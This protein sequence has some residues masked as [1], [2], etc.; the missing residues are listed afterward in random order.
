MELRRVKKGVMTVGIPLCS[1]TGKRGWTSC[2]AP[3]DGLIISLS[4]L[5]AGEGGTLIPEKKLRQAGYVPF[6]AKELAEKLERLKKQELHLLLDGFGVQYL[7][8]NNKEKLTRKIVHF[9]AGLEQ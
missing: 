4:H 1:V 9:L 5:E 8:K 2:E 3:D 6:V 7:K